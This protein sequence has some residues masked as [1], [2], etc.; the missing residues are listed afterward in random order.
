MHEE[1]EGVVCSAE[2]RV[3]KINKAVNP[4]GD[5]RS[6]ALIICDLAK[7][8][9]KGQYFAYPVHARDLRRAARRLEGRHRRLLRHH[10]GADRGRARRVLAVPRD[11]S[12]RHAAA[13]RGRPVL[14]RRRQGASP[15]DASGASPAIRPTLTFPLFLTT[16]RVV[17]HYLSGTQTRRIGPLVE[18]YPEPRIELHPRLAERRTASPA[19]TGCAI[20]TRRAAVVAQAHVV[21]TIRPDT[22]FIPYHWPGR[23]SRQPADAP[24][25]R[26]AQQDPRVQGVGLP[27]REGDA[28]ADLDAWR[29]EETGWLP[30]RRRRPGR[31]RERATSSSSI[32]RAAS[33][34]APA[35]RRAPS[36]TRTAASR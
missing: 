5:A 30:G 33:A 1:D 12:P 15:G 29:L 32:R 8:L 18:Q 2:G 16:G 13:V 21:R 17:S 26:S 4:P 10:V 3:Q 14:S 25:A 34:A 23:R 36:A 11:R 35:W 6:D 9:G 27:D 31:A 7:R 22:I 28:P 24:H 19:A 20:T